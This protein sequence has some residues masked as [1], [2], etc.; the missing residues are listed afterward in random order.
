MATTPRPSKHRSYCVY[1]G[2]FVEN[3][4][5]NNE[6]VIPKLLGGNRSTVIQVSRSL[7]SHIAT[8]IDASV[9]TDPMV[10][11]GRRDAGK[12][13]HSGKDPIP[14]WRGAKSLKE[15]E[16]W[17]SGEKNFRLEFP[18]GGTRVLN[19]KTRQILPQSVFADTGFI[20]EELRIDHVARFRFVLKTLLGVGWKL[21][22]NGLLSSM[23]TDLIRAIMFQPIS[24]T[25]K[26]NENGIGYIDEFMP[27]SSPYRENME[28]LKKVIVTAGETSITASEVDSRLEW[29]VVCLG[30]LVGTV[31][32][33]LVRSLLGDECA[34]R[35]LRLVV[36]EHA[37]RRSVLNRLKTPE[38]IDA[39]SQKG[40]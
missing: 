31:N 4:L 25:E 13:G 19:E 33:P 30:H 20:V 8:K 21:F 17:G 22:D 37:L 6:H 32:V 10:M 34:G 5:M 2:E 11:F 26:P 38:Q 39:T 9:A 14:S 15:G 36:E 23:D 3:D 35:T 12:R 18:K 1:A 28:A 27:N 24:F 40:T 29:S 7:N 16:P